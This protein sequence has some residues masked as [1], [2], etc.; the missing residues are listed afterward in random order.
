MNISAE[1]REEAGIVQLKVRGQKI[2]YI[3]SAEMGEAGGL[4]RRIG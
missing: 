3:S 4:G 1:V 2:L